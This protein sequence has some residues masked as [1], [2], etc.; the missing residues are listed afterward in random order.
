MR[1]KLSE[2]I[3]H[4]DIGQAERWPRRILLSFAPSA[5]AGWQASVQQ[6]VQRWVYDRAFFLRVGHCRRFIHNS[7]K[8]D[9]C[10]WT[11]NKYSTRQV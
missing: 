11:P 8:N 1:A 7:I 10:A 2:G 3:R 9:T 5:A 6:I 4:A